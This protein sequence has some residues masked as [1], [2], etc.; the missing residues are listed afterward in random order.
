MLSNFKFFN[1]QNTKN[2]YQN[3]Q[4]TNSREENTHREQNFSINLKLE[5]KYGR[6]QKRTSLFGPKENL[7]SAKV[8]YNT[9]GNSIKNVIVYYYSRDGIKRIIHKS[10]HKR[11]TFDFEVWY[12]DVLNNQ[13]KVTAEVT[14]GKIGKRGLTKSL[15]CSVF[16]NI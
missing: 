10:N 6:V 2:N 1:E 9:T 16:K 14:F 15:S 11:A 7:Y 5:K 4:K 12:R 8:S 3:K 13:L